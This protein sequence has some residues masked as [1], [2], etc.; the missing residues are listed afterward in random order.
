MGGQGLLVSRNIDTTI[1][2]HFVCGFHIEIGNAYLPRSLRVEHPQRQTDDR[3]VLNFT[4][5]TVAKINAERC[6]ISFRRLR[7]KD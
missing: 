7:L 5:A 1:S 6:S 4:P 3:K 2:A